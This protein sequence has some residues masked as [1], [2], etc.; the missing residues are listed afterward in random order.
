VFAR[1]DK[2]NN[3]IY[4][5]AD[6][7]FSWL[8][9]IEKGFVSSLV[10]N[11]NDNTNIKKVIL[12]THLLKQS[13][14]TDD[15]NEVIR[16]ISQ[17]NKDLVLYTQG[18]DVNTLEDIIK[19]H[20]WPSLTYTAPQLSPAEAAVLH[21]HKGSLSLPNVRVFPFASS[22]D[23]ERAIT[24]F[25][26]ANLGWATYDAGY[27]SFWK[28]ATR[29]LAMVF[30]DQW[31]SFIFNG[32][33]KLQS[34]EELYWL[35][36]INWDI[37]LWALKYNKAVPYSK[38][39][40][41]FWRKPA[42]DWFFNSENV[43][44][45]NS[46]R[47]PEYN[48]ISEEDMIF[49]GNNYFWRR[50][51]VWKWNTSGYHAVNFAKMKELTHLELA[52]DIN[53]W[54]IDTLTTGK[55]DAITL[56]DNKQN[57]EAL[58]KKLLSKFKYISAPQ[59]TEFTS[60]WWAEKDDKGRPM[61]KQFGYWMKWNNEITLWAKKLD[62]GIANE[63]AK[64]KGWTLD[65]STLEYLLVEVKPWTI[66]IVTTDNAHIY[67]KELIPIM[68]AI[69]KSWAKVNLGRFQIYLNDY[70]YKYKKNK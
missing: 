46:L 45:T 11:I 2:A 33:E 55:I 6:V 48:S 34:E 41:A 31:F 22:D 60:A 54:F 20:K 5:S 49:A 61:N 57:D 24:D 3:F 16:T 7:D 44:W 25:K 28:Q 56:Y 8:F 29:A 10:K 38:D 26:D 18:E 35:K 68:E 52:W 69:S 47:L 12:N 43:K 30:K 1:K 4:T 9:K 53:E 67:K 27:V 59:N 65:L 39:I 51:Q 15:Y 21:K 62:M 23:F 58:V 13:Y 36:R 70:I 17:L 14:N 66:A 64:K 63:I 19:N 32:I 40:L 42:T 37:S 50:L